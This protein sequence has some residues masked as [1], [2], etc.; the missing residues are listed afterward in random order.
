MKVK[1]RVK[2]LLL[3]VAALV[4]SVGAFAGCKIG[5]TTA[6]SY[7]KDKDALE[8]QVTYYANDGKFDGMN[9]NEKNIY[10]KA[11]SQVI[12]DFD[13]VSNI[14]IA[15]TDYIFD[16]WYKVELDENGAPVFEDKENN[17][18]KLTD[19]AVDPS[20]PIYIKEK[21]HLYFGAKWQVDV[22]L[23]LI[24][25]TEDGQSITT[26]KGVIENGQPVAY[27]SFGSQSSIQI[28]NSTDPDPENKSVDYTFYE[29]YSDEACTQP[30]AGTVQKPAAG[31]GNPKIY[32]KYIK[33][34]YTMVRS[35]NNV[36]NMMTNLNSDASYYICNDIDC[37][38]LAGFNL[39][40]VFDNSNKT[41]V[42]IIGNGHKISNIAIDLTGNSNTI[43]NGD[44][45][46][47]FGM[48]SSTAKISGL[49]FEKIELIA[50]IKPNSYINSMH[51][52]VTEAEEGAQFENVA[53]KSVKYTISIPETSTIDNI[54]KVDGVYNTDCWLFGGMTTDAAFLEKFTTVTVTDTSLIMGP[55]NHEVLIATK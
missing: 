27:K 2:L 48:L 10:Y 53:F 11:G 36:Q 4:A 33:G 20:K 24:L 34:V 50:K 55:S 29:Y 21:E 51:L 35:A 54:Q 28:N 19:E 43:Q 30:F 22:R 3:S 7:L 44:K 47:L 42:T 45:T 32:A 5:E 46:S 16:G 6:E 37:T 13:K 52:F 38:G 23:E 12:V 8:Q 25:V 31:T 40:F 9:L 49:T 15:R 39:W 18:V 26:A 14:S 41:N 1:T 17:V